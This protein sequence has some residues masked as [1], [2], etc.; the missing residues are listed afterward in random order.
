MTLYFDNAATTKI[1]DIALEKIIYMSK[2]NFANP[3]SVHKLGL[4]AEREITNTRKIISNIINAK[5]DE[6]IF[7]SGATEANNLALIGVS[8]ANKR[9]GNHIITQKTEHASVFESCKYLEENGFKITYLD[10]DN[11]G[12][13]DIEKLK[14]AITPE[15]ILVSLMHV[16]NETGAKL[17]LEE[18]GKS[19]KQKNDNVL[20]HTDCVQSLCKFDIDVNKYNIDLLSFSGHKL[21]APKGVGGLF[22]KKGIKIQSRTFGGSQEKKIRSGTENITGIVALGSSIEILYNDMQKNYEYIK[23]LKDS[24]I[25]IQNELEDVVINSSKDSSPYVVNLSFLGVKGEVLVHALEENNI[26]CS[27]GSACHKG[28][29]SEVLKHYGLS[30]DVCTSGLR[31]SFC[32]ENTLEEIDILKQNLIEIVPMLRRFKKR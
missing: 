8:L 9:T 23:C 3:S 21:H 1:N 24:F 20:F 15:T 30:S 29:G 22:I 28:S 16:N 10:N 19:I 5:E 2:E 6:I 26:Y 18:I 32:T 17:D 7:T 27:T 4:Y 25:D 14:N 11:Y 12:N 13:I 31:V